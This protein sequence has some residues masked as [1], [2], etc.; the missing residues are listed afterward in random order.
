MKS[1]DYENEVSRIASE[2][3][4]VLV[5]FAMALLVAQSIPRWFPSDH[6]PREIDDLVMREKWDAT[7]AGWSDVTTLFIGD[8]S[9]LMG[10]SASKLQSQLGQGLYN[11]GTISTAG[12]ESFAEMARAFIAHD[13]R[14]VDRVILLVSPTMVTSLSRSEVKQ[15]QRPIDPAMRALMAEGQRLQANLERNR[16]AQAHAIFGLAEIRT[17]LVPAIFE[18]PYEKQ[19]GFQ[20][21]F[22]SGLRDH[23]RADRGSAIDPVHPHGSENPHSR[24]IDA[25]FISPVIRPLCERVRSIL[26]A[27]IEFY[28]GIMPIAETPDA[29]AYTQRQAAMVANL[30][31]WLRADRALTNLPATL[32]ARFFSTETHLN[33]SGADLFTG[34]L[35]RSL[36]PSARN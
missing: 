35:A 3:A 36:R 19:F 22:P 20:Y 1:H 14:R 23:L 27:Q 26:P 28:V 33:A 10:F 21:G 17:N 11:L 9:C 32:P 34:A 8:S 18:A 5:I 6:P 2:F 12:L 25:Y 24:A 7:R 30:A 31:Q 15:I 16:L 29:A 13:A 4:R